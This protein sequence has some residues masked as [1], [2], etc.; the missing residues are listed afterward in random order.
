MFAR[1]KTTREN[2]GLDNQRQV[3]ASMSK[4]HPPAM[5]Q[6]EQGEKDSIWE[7]QAGDEMQASLKKEEYRRRLHE[8]YLQKAAA[9]AEKEFESRKTLML[10]KCSGESD[11]LDG[12][13]HSTVRPVIWGTG[14]Y[15]GLWLKAAAIPEP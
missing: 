6:E 11:C 9:D 12:P 15:R 7:R 8:R 10:G 13:L 2:M 14:L 5:D 3:R 1:L 4:P